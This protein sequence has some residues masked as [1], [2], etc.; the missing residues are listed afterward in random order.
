MVEE[1]GEYEVIQEAAPIPSYGDN[2]AQRAQ[3]FQYLAAQLENVNDQETKRLGY[4]MLKALVE[5]VM[6]K[7]LRGLKAVEATDG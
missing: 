1:E 3:A 6:D 2:I 4:A 5:K 7:P